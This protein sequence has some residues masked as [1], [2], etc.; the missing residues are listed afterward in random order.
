M[1]LVHVGL[2]KTA[3]TTL[4]RYIFPRIAEFLSEFKYNDK[5]IMRLAEK[6]HYFNLNRKEMMEFKS[7]LYECENILISNE[8]LVDW[9]PH[10]W[11]QAADK[12]LELF[13]KDSSILITVREPEEY[14]TS[15]YLQS[16]HE[17]NI[18]YPEDFFI[19]SEIYHAIEKDLK[20]SCLEYLDINSFSLERLYNLYSSRFKKVFFVPLEHVGRLEFL[21][22]SF[23]IHDSDFSL[24]V[25][26]FNESKRENIAYSKSAVHLTFIRENILRRFGLKTLGSHDA[27]TL[28]IYHNL[29]SEVTINNI[30]I[31]FNELSFLSKIQAIPWRI[32]NKI[33]VKTGWRYLMQSIVNNYFPYKKY[34]LPEGF[35]SEDYDVIMKNRK[36]LR[37]WLS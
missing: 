17:G 29:S 14:F 25:K 37:K 32:M 30:N 33:L 11:E 28:S 35:F 7:Y 2:G 9:N 31:P 5:K 24:L 8:S 12:N 15:V 3:T 36:Y 10:N 1:I 13:G 34:K 19:S 20:R 27:S 22:E 6:Y 23:A 21:S 18:K 26:I 16:L 4:Q